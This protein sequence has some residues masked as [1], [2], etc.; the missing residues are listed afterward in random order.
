MAEEIHE[1]GLESYESE[2]DNRRKKSLSQNKHK[3]VAQLLLNF[4]STEGNKRLDEMI[5]DLE[6][7]RRHYRQNLE[8]IEIE[9]KKNLASLYATKLMIFNA[10]EKNMIEISC[11]T[12]KEIRTNRINSLYLWYKER[13]K[14]IEDLRKINMKSYKELDEI[15]DEEMKT[16]ADNKNE[17]QGKDGEKDEENENI[18]KVN[19]KIDKKLD[20][21]RND[22]ILDKKMINEYKRKILSKS[23]EEKMNRMQTSEPME[24]NDEFFNIKDNAELTKTLMSLKNQEFS[25]GGNY[26]TFYS[27]KYGTNTASLA[28][29]RSTENDFNTFRDTVKGGDHENNFFPSYNRESKLYFPPLSKETK[30]SYSYYRPQYNYENMI[31]EK[32]ILDTKMKYQAEKRNQEEIKSQIEKMGKIRAK[33]KE[34]VNNKYEIKNVIHMYVKSH[35]FSSPLLK[36][37]KLKPSKS[38][39]DI[40]PKSRNSKKDNLYA[41]MSSKNQE[42]NL[43]VSQIVQRQSSRSIKK[44][45]NEPIKEQENENDN[46]DKNEQNIV[47]ISPSNNDDNK[48]TL[49]KKLKQEKKII[50]GFNNKIKIDTVKNIENK[51]VLEPLKLNKIKIKLKVHREKIQNNM[52]NNI[53]KFV[54]KPSSEIVT[55]LISTDHLF[56][57]NKSYQS[58]CNLYNKGKTIDINNSQ[59]KNNINDDNNTVSKDDD[60][61][62]S[63]NFCLSLFDQ[64]N[65]RKINQNRHNYINNYK[66][67]NYSNS[68]KKESKIKIDQLHKTYN[69]YKN[70]LLN[71]RRTVSDWKRGEYLNLIDKLKRNKTPKKE[72]EKKE[73]EI[74][75]KQI[76]RQTSLLNAIVNPKDHF[77]YSQYFLPRTGTLLLSRAEEQKNKKKDKN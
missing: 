42:F 55:K 72:K 18:E 33:Y 61:S 29:F 70:N 58:L 59:V 10:L 4:S 64:G 20:S 51:I 67:V 56:Q 46:D 73:E 31:Y 53:K 15:T 12:N 60:E 22:E 69:Q 65:L 35:D 30:F 76:K 26:S 41:K 77:D 39:N 49:Q 9:T 1:H 25:G 19:I 14:I 17:E 8:R 16:W 52:L 34:E 13:T 43:G 71:L 63:H 57:T 24:T 37:Y 2:R 23:L 66:S 62:F 21:H 32:Q 27:Y 50:S 44:I 75:K 38:M 36:K 47:P 40:N 7:F 54:D 5:S 6:H 3:Y 28:K 11:L 68:L 74:K 45:K 48:S